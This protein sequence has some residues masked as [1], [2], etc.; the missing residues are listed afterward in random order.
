MRVMFD[1]NIVISAAFFPNGAA[2]KFC[3]LVLSRHRVFVSSYSLD[4]AWDVARRKFRGNER[5]LDVFMQNNGIS[6]LKTPENLDGFLLP[7]IRDMDDYPVLASAMNADM[8]VLVTGD[9]DFDDVKINR[10]QIMTI[11]AFTER[12]L[13]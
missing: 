4:E 8:D 12:F 3:R 7:H 6:M 5:A 9:K 10:P 13:L 2:A 1:T 11:A